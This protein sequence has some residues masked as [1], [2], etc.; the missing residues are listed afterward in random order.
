M[1]IYISHIYRVFKRMQCDAT[2]AKPKP[3]VQKTPNSKAPGAASSAGTTPVHP[4]ASITG[5][6][7]PNP[8]SSE[9]PN[10]SQSTISMCFRVRQV[11]K[12]KTYKI[13]IVY[14]LYNLGSCWDNS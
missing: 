5:G 3:R 4:D 8:Y 10:K 11:P 2:A 14:I 13:C 6:R 1:Y 12:Q 9:T 7:R